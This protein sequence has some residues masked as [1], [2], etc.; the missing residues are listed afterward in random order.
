[1]EYAKLG[2]SGITVS[3]LCVGCIQR[4]IVGRRHRVS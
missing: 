1:M 4:E 2:N 3:K